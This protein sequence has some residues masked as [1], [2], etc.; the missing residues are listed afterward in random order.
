MR[1]RG[2]CVGDGVGGCDY[3]GFVARCFIHQSMPGAGAWQQWAY[4]V[5]CGIRSIIHQGFNRSGQSGPDANGPF[6]FLRGLYEGK[7]A[8]VGMTE[9]G[10]RWIMNEWAAPATGQTR[11][12]PRTG[13]LCSLVFALCGLTDCQG[14]GN[15]GNVVNRD[16]GHD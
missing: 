16:A 4:D 11:C 2:A 1:F 10:L 8:G 14:E 12:W 7:S 6:S 15:E 5:L 9:A 3:G 13:L